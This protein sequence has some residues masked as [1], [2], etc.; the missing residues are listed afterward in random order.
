[1][2]YPQTTPNPSFPQLE[3]EVLSLWK[4]E[5]IF[6]KSIR[7]VEEFVFYD[8]PPFANGL[9]HYGHFLTGFEKD[10][11]ARY[12]TMK[13]KMVCRRFGWDC[14]GLPPEMESEKELKVSGKQQI[15]EFGID[16]F[17]AHCR[18]S[19]L[20]YVE[21]WKH[22]VT[23]QARWVDFDNS[24]KT[25]DLSYMESVL[26]AFKTLY[27][28]N[29]IYKAMRVMPYSWKCETPVSDFETRIDNAYREKQS[30][31]VTIAVKLLDLPDALNMALAENF[32]FQDKLPT[33]RLLV[34]TTTPWTLPSNLAIAVGNEIEYSCFLKDN[35]CYIVASN[36]AAKYATEI[37]ETC[38]ATIK[39]A[40]LVGVRYE[41]IFDYFANHARAFKILPADFVTTEDGTG[42][43]HI[44]PGFGEDDYRLCEQ[45][46]IELV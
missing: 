4:R 34:W 22:F 29:L 45:Y 23:R 27:D 13:G 33:I 15:E 18:S 3:H 42:A 35:Q 19:V 30:K 10:L 25:M 1:M 41:V 21:E 20:R 31:S 5:G 7:G 9:P 37:G 24:Y 8:G 6:N 16:K 28:R 12:Q 26:W 39:G 11:V 38:I 46:N 32:Y 2:Y 17:N 14:H 36:L 43:V 44:A 40:I